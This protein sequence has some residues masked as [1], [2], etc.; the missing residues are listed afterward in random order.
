MGH[1]ITAVRITRDA[2]PALRAV[3]RRSAHNGFCWRR[4]VP[5]AG[6]TP[7]TASSAS[8]PLQVPRCAQADPAETR[9]NSDRDTNNSSFA[10][11]SFKFLFHLIS[12][13][14]V[15]P[16]TYIYIYRTCIHVIHEMDV[17]FSAHIPQSAHK[18][19]SVNQSFCYQHP[20]PYINASDK[21][22]FRYR[23]LTSGCCKWVYTARTFTI[24][25]E[26]IIPTT[27]VL[28]MNTDCRS[29]LLRIP[30]RKVRG[31]CTP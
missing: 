13:A 18:L 14:A 9:S 5:P 21:T 24:P 25:W 30:C 3:W 1:I 31:K 29:V 15:D 17:S 27:S 23:P 12:S 19:T 10:W 4:H 16:N 22:K 6:S 28:M 20:S 26:A 2:P 8:Q 7:G 11:H